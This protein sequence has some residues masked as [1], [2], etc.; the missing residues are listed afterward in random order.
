MYYL[1]PNNPRNICEAPQFSD[2]YEV[3]N[4]HGLNKFSVLGNSVAVKADYS[5]AMAQDFRQQ[6]KASIF[7]YSSLVTGVEV[8]DQDTLVVGLVGGEVL[9]DDVETQ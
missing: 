4:Q 5:V 1:D 3:S 9:V 7:H 2:F 6:E 8:F